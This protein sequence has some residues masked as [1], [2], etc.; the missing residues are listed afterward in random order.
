MKGIIISADDFWISSSVNRAIL[1]L[2]EKKLLSGT[3][4]MMERIS[5][6]TQDDIEKLKKLRDDLKITIGLHIE[7]GCPEYSK[8]IV[9]QYKHYLNIFWSEP[10]VIDIHM[11]S[12]VYRDN[13]G[14]LEVAKFAQS[15]WIPYRN[16][17]IDWLPNTSLT[18]VNK[19]YNSTRKSRDEIIS[20]ID[21]VQEWDTSE[22]IFHPWF[23]DK[24]MIS[25]LNWLDLR[26]QDYLRVID[27]N[28]YIESVWV[29][30]ASFI[31]LNN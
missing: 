9:R 29:D 19:A 5:N 12:K 23:E 28:Q 8:R 13:G 20:Y 2:A 11:S 26:K 3:S 25:S 6:D 7:F 24:I 22:I 31:I 15:K 30:K 16:H 14:A 17:E 21:S 10:D 18:T 4:V 27:L 1:D